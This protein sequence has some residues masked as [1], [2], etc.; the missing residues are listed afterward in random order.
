MGALV[1][2]LVSVS[3]FQGEVVLQCRV[4]DPHASSWDG[5]VWARSWSPTPCACWCNRSDWF[6][7]FP[8]RYFPPRSGVSVMETFY[9]DRRPTLPVL[10]LFS[11]VCFVL[12]CFV[13]LCSV[14]V[15]V[16]VFLLDPALGITGPIGASTSHLMRQNSNSAMEFLCTLTKAASDATQLFLPASTSSPVRPVQFSGASLKDAP[17]RIRRLEAIRASLPRYVSFE[18]RAMGQVRRHPFGCS[19]PAPFL[20]CMSLV[21]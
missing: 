21:T 12:F 7:V 20:L 14:F 16:F 1:S 11:S 5:V 6:C 13:L 2:D 9:S 15:F 17:R 4:I 19:N 18:T 10:V 3:V 8:S